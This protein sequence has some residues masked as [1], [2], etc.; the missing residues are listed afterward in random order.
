MCIRDRSKSP[1]C[2]FEIKT[3]PAFP[4]RG[5]K[6]QFTRGRYSHRPDGLEGPCLHKC[7]A[8]ECGRWGGAN[9][10]RLLGLDGVGGVP[11]NQLRQQCR[12]SFYGAA[13]LA[14]CEANCVNEAVELTPFLV[15][16]KIFEP[17]RGGMDAAALR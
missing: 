3:A 14:K 6:A 4:K 7:S 17:R 5:A 16:E 1:V 13:E 10:V 9:A 12:R 8:A 15:G 11:L 2:V